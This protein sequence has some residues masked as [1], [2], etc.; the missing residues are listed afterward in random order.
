MKRKRDKGDHRWRFP[1]NGSGIVA[2]PRRGRVPD[3]IFRE[4]RLALNREKRSGRGFV[5]S[6]DET[7]NNERWKILISILAGYTGDAALWP[8][9][10]LGP[11]TEQILHVADDIEY[12]N[13]IDI[14][15]EERTGGRIYNNNVKSKIWS[16]LDAREP[17]L[18][19]ASGIGRHLPSSNGFDRNQ[20]LPKLDTSWT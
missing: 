3:S 2:V 19:I 18:K 12:L 17:I 13:R 4:I 7:K 9:P 10:Q 6:Y 5:Q 16:F 20:R 11:P 8:V 15:Q 1:F 14:P